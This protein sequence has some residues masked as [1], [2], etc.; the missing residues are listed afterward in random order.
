[1]DATNQLACDII[2]LLQQR[3]ETIAVAESCT[4]GLLAA[5]LTAVPGC[6]EVLNYSVVTYSNEV[7]TREL[8]VSPETLAQ[9]GAVSQEV[10]QQMA[11]GVGAKAQAQVGVGI[12]GIAGPGGATAQKPVGLVYIGCCYRGTTQVRQFIFTGDREKVRRQGV[13]QALAM[14]RL[15]LTATEG[16]LS[17]E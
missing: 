13:E 16:G 15:A 11:Q 9:V 3:Q 6:S 10:A 5:A 8:G 14:V 2:G 4:G 7:K 17:R 1:M 12:T